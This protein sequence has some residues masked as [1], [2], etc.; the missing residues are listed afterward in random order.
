MILTMKRM[1]IY[2]ILIAFW[3]DIDKNKEK[4]KK[5]DLNVN[6]FAPELRIKHIIK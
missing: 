3:K 4:L 5:A 6:C 1:R 2:D